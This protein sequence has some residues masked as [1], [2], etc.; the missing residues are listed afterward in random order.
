MRFSQRIGKKPVRQSLQIESIDTPLENRLWNNFLSYFINEIDST[1]FI[2]DEPDKSKISKNI[3]E[4]FFDERIDEIPSYTDGDIYVNGVIDYIKE[5]F[6]QAEWFEKY[7]FIEFI[8]LLDAKV[9]Q[10]QFTKKCNQTLEKESAGYRI[11]EA[12]IVQLTAEEEI[13]A[14]EE[15]ISV[16]PQ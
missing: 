10:T 15:A 7:D 16:H 12:K 3:W 8:A 13:K 2:D 6:F 5:W 9:I 1:S 11:V 4:E 14:I